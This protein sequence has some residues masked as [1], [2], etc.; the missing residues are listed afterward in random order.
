MSD[1]TEVEGS[2]FAI[3]LPD[4]WTPVPAD[5]AGFAGWLD[6]QLD[7]AALEGDDRAEITVA[8]RSMVVEG[9][10]NGLVLAASF[11]TTIDDPA[12]ERSGVVSAGMYV[13]VQP[14]GSIEGGVSTFAFLTGLREAERLGDLDHL[15][16]PEVVELGEHEAVKSVTLDLL[17]G[18]GG[19]QVPLLGVTYHLGIQD[20][21]A[22]LAIG[23]RTPCV[24]LAEEFERLFDDIA[25]TVEVQ[26]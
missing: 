2:P 7:A 8:L 24:W 4:E 13:A 21:R 11:L 16:P 25:A 22:M 18:A 15:R 12:L 9:R 26:G 19:A 17:T 23:F 10:A 20:R 5:A 6:R 3:V 1:V 14:S